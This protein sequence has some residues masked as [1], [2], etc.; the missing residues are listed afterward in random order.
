MKA[1]VPDDLSTYKP[2]VDR[3]GLEHQV[4]VVHVRKNV[5]KLLRKAK[6]WQAWKSRLRSLL[7]ELPDDGGKRLMAMEREAR[8]EPALCCGLRWT[9]ARN[10]AVCCATNACARYAIRTM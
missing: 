2:V 9:Y 8:E 7:D 1:V 4:C 5:A 6:V 10:G 3:L